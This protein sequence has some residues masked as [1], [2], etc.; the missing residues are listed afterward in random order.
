MLIEFVLKEYFGGLRIEPRT[1]I[2]L[3]VAVPLT[4]RET[5]LELI[6]ELKANP[7]S[8]L[9]TQRLRDA[10]AEVTRRRLVK[11][12]K[13]MRLEVVDVQTGS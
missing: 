5:R 4:I 8:P 7:R 6:Y 3:F 10:C 9:N 1:F 13:R 12:G 2:E 11:G